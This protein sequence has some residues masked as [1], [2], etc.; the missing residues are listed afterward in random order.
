MPILGPVGGHSLKIRDGYVQPH[1]PHFQTPVTEWPPFYFSHFALTCDPHFQN[2]VSLN[3][4]ILKIKMLS[5]NDPF[6]L[7]INALTEWAPFSP[8]NGHSLICTQYLFGKEGF[9]VAK[10]CTKIES[11][12]KCP[13]FFS[14]NWRLHWKTPFFFIVLTKWPPIFILS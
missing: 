10:F 13:P 6:F 4:P 1:W 12:T 7:E 5:L 11:L 14:K 9:I 2:A 8:I 3:D